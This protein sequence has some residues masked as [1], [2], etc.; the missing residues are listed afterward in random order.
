MRTRELI[1]LMASSMS[2]RVATRSVDAERPH[3]VVTL[4]NCDQQ[5]RELLSVFATVAI[6]CMAD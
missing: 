5:H 6:V 4:S 1:Q 2:M 3:A